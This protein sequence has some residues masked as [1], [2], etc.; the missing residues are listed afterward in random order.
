VRSPSGFAHRR[1]K[2]SYLP[3]VEPVFHPRCFT[4]TRLKPVKTR[5]SS[6]DL[7]KAKAKAGKFLGALAR[8]GYGARGLV[9]LLIAWLAVLAALGSRGAATGSKGA[10]RTFLS[11]PLGWFWLGLVALGLLSFA[12]WSL[13][14]ATTNADS[15]DVSASKTS[16]ARILHLISSI[17]YLGLAWWALNLALGWAGGNYDSG[18]KGWTAWLLG[19]PFGSWLVIAAGAAVVCTGLVFCW[20]A[21]YD[22]ISEDLRDEARDW[23]EVFGRVGYA[24]RGLV[25]NL[26]GIFLIIAGLQSD[27]SE[28]EGLGG[29][30][31][32]LQQQPY[33]WMVLGLTAVGLGAFGAF[34]IAL[35]FYGRIR[36]PSRDD[37]NF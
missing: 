31:R 17:F 14:Q 23:L 9:Y 13:L 10:L 33:G 15:G 29:A 24:A 18:A 32:S 3:V 2:A 21:W 4:L 7:T 25:F 22:D 8:F 16:L 27:P 19:K 5:L 30:L 1:A 34:N 11:E 20:R 12:L 28:A 6:K 35:A 36:L 26:I 37:A